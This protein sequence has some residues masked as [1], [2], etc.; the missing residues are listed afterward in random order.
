MTS[1]SRSNNQ[2][3]VVN[4]NVVSKKILWFQ[5][6]RAMFLLTKIIFG[7][8]AVWYVVNYIDDQITKSRLSPQ[9]QV[10]YVHLNPNGAFAEEDVVRIANVHLDQSIFAIDLEHAQKLL[11]RRPELKMAEIRRHP[12][13]TIEFQI[14]ARQPYAWIECPARDFLPKNKEK[15][16]LIDAEGYLFPCT[17]MQFQSALSLPVIVVPPEDARS[18]RVG[19]KIEIKAMRRAMNLLALAHAS[20]PAGP[21]WISRIAPYRA[22]GIKVTTHEGTEATFGINDHERQM[23]D[24]F[25]TMQHARSIGKAIVSINLI[26]QKNFPVE[27]RSRSS[28]ATDP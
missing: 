14:E 18:L 4:Y 10:R 9:Y 25:L 23:N 2:K 12:P 13:S 26:P 20:S 17:T 28:D 16:H 1:N 11:Q 19:K 24:L 6:L 21:T 7:V 15:G 22:W 5:S 3:L 8:I 27:L